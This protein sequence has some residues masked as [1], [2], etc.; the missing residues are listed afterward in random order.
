VQ[1]LLS[2]EQQKARFAQ[3]TGFDD[4]SLPAAATAT[5]ALV[6][7]LLQQGALIRQQ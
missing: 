6:A 2:T 3:Q 4:G 1:Q 7:D 5:S